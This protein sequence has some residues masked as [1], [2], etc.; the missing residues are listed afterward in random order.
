MPGFDKNR[1]KDLNENLLSCSI[2]LNIFD[3]AVRSG[4]RKTQKT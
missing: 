4:S 1:F 3:N 2:C